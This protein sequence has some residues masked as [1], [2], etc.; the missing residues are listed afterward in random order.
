[1]NLYLVQRTDMVGYDEYSAVVVAAP[2]EDTAAL[3]EAGW[4]WAT[5]GV[6]PRGLE[7]RV[8]KIGRAAKGVKG[9]VLASFHAG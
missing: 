3:V 7:L 2:D 8:D 1:M 6:N 4:G 9:V 5:N